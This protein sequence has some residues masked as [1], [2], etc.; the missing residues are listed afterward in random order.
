[1]VLGLPTWW[2]ALPSAD[3]TYHS[4]LTLN[5]YAFFNDY[6]LEEGLSAIRPDYIIIDDIL[7][8]VLLSFDQFTT[9]PFYGVPGD[10]FYAFLDEQ[11]QLVLELENK[12]HG[13]IEVYAVT[14]D[15][16]D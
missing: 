15:E 9:S 16:S 2:F 1:K 3:Y 11:G 6:T 5:Y 14:W 13:V 12:W 7:R 4:S 10:E 8:G